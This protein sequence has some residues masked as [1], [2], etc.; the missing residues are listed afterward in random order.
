MQCNRWLKANP[1]LTGEELTKAAAKQPWDASVQALVA[2]PAALKLLDDNLQW[3]TDL[4]NAVLDQQGEVMDAVQRMRKKAKDGGKLDTT[5]EQ[6][7]EVTTI[8]N[9]NVIVIKPADPQVIYV[10]TYN[11][12]VVYGAPVY[13]YPP[14]VYP[15][16]SASA[17]WATAA[18]SF[19]VGVM[20]GAFWSGCCHGGYGWG[21][22]WGGN[23]NIV[24]NNNFNQRY[25]YARG[26]DRTNIRGGDRANN[27]W[28]HN[29]EHRRS[30]PYSDRSTAER[31]GGSTRDS[32]GRTERFDRSGQSSGDRGGLGDRGGAG[33]RGGLGDRGN[34]ASTRDVGGSVNRG[35]SGLR[36]TGAG[37]D[38]IGD[39]S[40]G[41]DTGSRQSAFNGSESRARSDASSNRGFSSSR[42]SSFGGSS[43]RSSSA[44]A[45]RSG[46]G[47]RR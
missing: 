34:Q 11:P 35:Q 26:G 39:R 28:R 19:G 36:D 33:D 15:T 46:G 14:I 44:G 30:V 22:G 41:R 9:K 40:V 7:I 47:R 21:C 38:R 17:V 25:G 10:P 12:V 5:K 2:F 32:A 27:S 20:M 23:N 24:I 8:E 16:Y 45:G 18:V 6:K 29:P 31:F 3:T 1:K 37:Q 4:G 43:G 42:Q 13:A